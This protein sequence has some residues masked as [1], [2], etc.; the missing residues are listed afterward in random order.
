[1]NSFID[2]HSL[3]FRKSSGQEKLRCP[4]CND[5]RTDKRDRSLL[6]NHNEGYGKCFYCDALTFRESKELEYKY[7]KPKQD[8]QNYTSLSDELVK[9]C[10]DERKIRQETLIHFNITQER[11]YQPKR[12]K[13]VN[14]IVFNYFEGS[15]I[16]N[17]KYRDGGK[18]FTQFKGGK[19]IMYNINSVIGSDE[20]WIVE[21]EFDVLAL[22]EAGVRSVVSVPNGANDNDDYWKNSESYL[23]E[24]KKF[25][26]AT[27]K[28]E[29]GIDLREKIAQRLGR[30]RC[31]FVEWHGKDANEDLINGKI[32]ESIRNIKRF[33]VGGTFSV[34]DLYENILNLYDEGLPK[35]LRIKN[36]SFGNLNEVWT[37]MRGHLVVGTGI[38]SH[39]KSS[40]LEWYALNLVNEYDMKMS[41][42]SPEHSPMELHQ[43]RL[44]EKVTGKPFFGNGRINKSEIIRYKQWAK[45]KIYLTGA[46]KGEFP[47]WN[48]LFDKFKEQ[49]FC[50]G[51]DIFV[52]DAFNKVD[53][54]DSGDEKSNIRKVLTKLTMFA[55]MNNV[56]IFLIAHPTKMKKKEDGNFEVPTLYDVSGSADFRNQTHDGFT[57][58][59][60]FDT[61]EQDGFTRFINMKTKYQFQGEITGSVD[62]EY[63]KGNG[64]YYAR[65]YHK[66]TSDWTKAY[67]PKQTAIL[68][69]DDFEQIDECP[70]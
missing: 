16:V 28:D 20:V 13:E 41:F 53:F 67:E 51:I 66:D 10:Y 19:P 49:L 43:S 17:K 48:W 22:Y 36:T 39:G 21:G 33:P 56:V 25:I 1:M 42:F 64:R 65:G 38:P 54:D 40:F 5:Q 31:E 18:G 24:V 46:D 11:F 45:E 60:F 61:V 70:F 52:I 7:E 9:W 4:V 63:D 57:I 6:V 14:N 59:R 8:W 50:Y 62:F 47:T 37:T 32:K 29:K 30:Y 34:D 15:Q 68:P 2:W 58:Y 44:I 35:T 12:Q 27:D 3:P 26:I 55:Q 69:N 23:K